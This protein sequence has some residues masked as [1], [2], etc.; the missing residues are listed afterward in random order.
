MVNQA[1]TDLSLPTCSKGNNDHLQGGV[2]P[3]FLTS[4]QIHE[5]WSWAHEKQRAGSKTPTTQGNHKE[6]FCL[7]RA[8]DDGGQR[9]RGKGF[10]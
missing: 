7:S 10:L 4:S 5:T 8:L 6:A 2:E 9:G 3:G 1:E